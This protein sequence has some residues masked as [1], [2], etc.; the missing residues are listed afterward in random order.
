MADGL[1]FVK[2]R[3]VITSLLV[4]DLAQVGLASYRALLP[5]LAERL[6]MGV[7]GYGMLSAAP[8]VGSIAGAGFL[9]MLGDMKYKGLYTVFGVLSYC[10]AL[11]VLALSG[12]IALSLVA[13]GVLGMMNSIQA[14]PRNSAILA[15]SPERLRGRVEAFRSTLAGGG[16]PVGY[17]VS[18]TLA[19]AL[20]A[21]GALLA[22]AAACAAV[23]TGVALARK[24]LRDPY[25]GSAAPEE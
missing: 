16:P 14:I 22:G 12:S 11:V 8:G 13:A 5:V 24:E 1:R 20:G 17:V 25:L 10:V 19:T 3:P 4:L 7:T 15:I 18:G 9:L 6:G 21:P 2:S 23:V